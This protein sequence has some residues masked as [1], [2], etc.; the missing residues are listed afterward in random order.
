MQHQLPYTTSPGDELVFD[1]GSISG[2][3]SFDINFYVADVLNS[4]GD[5]Q[6]VLNTAK[7]V[8][9]WTPLDIRDTGGTDNAIANAPCPTCPP[10]A[11][12]DTLEISSIEIQKG[13]VIAINNGGSQLNPGDVLEYTLNFQVSDYYAVG[14]IIIDDLISDGQHLDTGFIPTFSITDREGGTVNGNFNFTTVAAPTT[15]A[16]LGVGVNMI[17]DDSSV[18]F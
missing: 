11:N 3:T 9:D 8:G 2:S 5:D 17:H 16:A 15:C 7:V 6:N 18:V 4:N 13:S 1:L 10:A 12:L 14:N